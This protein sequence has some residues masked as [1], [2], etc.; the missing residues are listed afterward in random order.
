MHRHWITLPLLVTLGCAAAPAS[1]GAPPPAST[2]SPHAE[3]EPSA[4][5]SSPR[6]TDAEVSCGALEC[7]LY[8]TPAQALGAVLMTK[9]AVIAFGEAHAQKGAPKVASATTRFRD[10]LLPVLAKDASDL[11]LELP[12]A[13]GK[14]GADETKTAEVQ[15]PVVQQQQSSNKNEFVALAE[16]AK[17]LGVRP[18]VLRPTCADFKAVAD[19]GDDGVPKMLTLIAS[20]SADLLHRILDRNQREGVSRMVLGYGGAMHNDVTPAAGRE[21]WSFGPALSKRTGGRYVELDLIV[22]EFIKDNDSWRALPWYAHFDAD[23]HPSKVTLFQLGPG[24]YV[25][26]FA[27]SKPLPPSGR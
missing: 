14:C 3:A 8:D 15:R 19:A 11:V 27:R 13:D 17:T 9:P 25:L 24:S 5:P 20:L 7:R 16:Q 26:I 21:P 2:I 23:K 4:S 1:D 10:Q 6:A 18:H 12:I 22:P